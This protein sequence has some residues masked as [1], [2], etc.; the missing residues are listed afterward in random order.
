MY[1]H[2]RFE[3]IR[4]FLQRIAI[5]DCPKSEQYRHKAANVDVYRK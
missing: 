2:P 1:T 4:P 3:V 5:D